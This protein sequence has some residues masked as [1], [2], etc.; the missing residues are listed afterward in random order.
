MQSSQIKSNPQSGP[1]RII[2]RIEVT[3]GAAERINE[4]VRRTGQT[5]VAV[6]RR[7]TE[8]LANQP[9]EIQAEVLGL[10][11]KNLRSN[12]AMAILKQMQGKVIS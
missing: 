7:A 10:Y 9:E 5:K 12:V 3:P 2:M 1:R 6:M 4:I 8:W 11:P